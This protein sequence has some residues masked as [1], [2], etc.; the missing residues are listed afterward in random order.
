MALPKIKIC[1]ITNL[2]DAQVA[3]EAGADA[4]GFV[5]YR[6][7]PRYID[8]AMVKN[9]VGGLPPFVL[10]VGVFVNEEAKVVR[11]IVDDCGLAFAQV[12]GDETAAYCSTVGR[13]PLRRSTKKEGH[14]RYQS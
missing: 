12:H 8:P 1:G 6:G 11:D 13:L 10:P 7:S 9:I 14:Q 5:L 2:A 3:V 4:L